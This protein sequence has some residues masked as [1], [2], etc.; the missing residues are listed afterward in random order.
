MNK[1]N[2]NFNN[3]NTEINN[4]IQPSRW[5]QLNKINTNKG[6]KGQGHSKLNEL[7]IKDD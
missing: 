5:I 6:F 3:F 2:Y 4:N 1:T 7:N